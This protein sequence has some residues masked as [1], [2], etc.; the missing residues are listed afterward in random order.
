MVNKT[1]LVNVRFEQ[2]SNGQIVGTNQYAEKYPRC[3]KS[4][5]A[6]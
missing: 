6:E 4:K 2:A 3:T 1:R 5:I